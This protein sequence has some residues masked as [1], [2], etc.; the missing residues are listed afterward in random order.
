MN[1]PQLRHSL[2]TVGE[3]CVSAFGKGE[4]PSR[5]LSRSLICVLW[6]SRKILAGL[7][8]NWQYFKLIIPYSTFLQ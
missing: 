3:I 4:Q 1:T 2:H 7:P 5:Y 8:A 6:V